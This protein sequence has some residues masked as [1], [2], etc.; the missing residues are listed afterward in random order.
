MKVESTILIYLHCS[1]VLVD[2]FKHRFFFYPY[3]V[4]KEHRDLP[5]EEYC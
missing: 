5:I 2:I 1:K 3:I 4:L